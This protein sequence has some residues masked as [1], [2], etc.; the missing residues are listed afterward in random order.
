MGS[1]MLWACTVNKQQHSK[2][3][4]LFFSLAFGKASQISI[5]VHGYNIA[6][7]Q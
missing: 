6:K 5:T 1:F 4:E 7:L 3:T 2:I